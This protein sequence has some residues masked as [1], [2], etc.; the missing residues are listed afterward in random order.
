MSGT[1]IAAAGWAGGPPPELGPPDGA[2]DTV[3]APAVVLVRAWLAAGEAALTRRERRERRR[4]QLLTGDERSLA[5]T[6]AF[7]DRVLRPGNPAVA[8]AQLREVS[9]GP[10]PPFLSTVDRVLLRAGVRLGAVA[11]R[12]VMPLTRRRLRQLVG[13]LVV[14]RSDPA[15]AR[16]LRRLRE[17][18]FAVNVNLLGEYVLGEE[19]AG[20]RLA[21]IEA[22]LAR[23]DI[24]YVSVK[25]SAV[26]SQ[27]NLWGYEQTLQR[28]MA[29][30]R[31]LYRAAAGAAG[32]PKFLNLDMEEY[33]DLRLTVDA[34]TRLLDEPELHGADAGIVLQAYLP[35]SFDVLREIVQ[36]ATRRHA[37]AGGTVK[38]RIVKGAN[39]AMESVDAAMHGWHRAP[40]ASKAETDA[41]YIRMLD[42][43]LERHRLSAVRIGIASHNLFDVAWGR[44]LAEARGVAGQVEVEMLQGMA[45]GIDRAVLAATGR[46]RLYTP[47]VAASDFDSA[48]AYLFR[49]LQENSH[50]ENFLRSSFDLSRDRQAFGREQSRF[51]ASVARRWQVSSEP[52]RRTL[53]DGPP[54][55]FRNV[56]DTDATDP[57]ARAVVL[58]ALASWQP[59]ELPAAITATVGIDR[60]VEAAAAAGGWWGRQPPAARGDLLRAVAAELAAHRPALLAVMAHEA[61]KTLAEGDGEVSEAVD[62]AS[63]YAA[64]IPGLRGDGDADAG[65]TPLGVVLVTP[66]WNFP[67]AIPTGGVLAALG[68]GNTVVLK[69]PPQTPQCALAVAEAVWAACRAQGVPA[70]VL[71]F[72]RCPEEVVGEHLV[73]HSGV[74]GI[75]LTGARET[76]QRF[77]R[78]APHTPLFAETSG[79]NA[80][81]VM[82][83]A[84]LDLAAADLV[85]SAFGHAGQKCSAASLA[86]CVGDVYSSGRF[87]R[88]LVDAAASLVPGPAGDPATTVAPLIG[89]PSRS[90]QRALTSLDPGERWLLEPRLVDAERHLWS[91]GIKDGV[92]PGSWF[93]QT[94]CFGPVLGL[95]PAAD[96]EEALALQNGTPYGLTGGIHTLDPRAADRWLARVQVGNAYVNRAITGAVVQRQPFGGWKASV[97][98]PGAKAGGPN[99]VAQLGRWHDAGL[100]TRGDDPL[101]AI[102]SWLAGVGSLL[103]APARRWLVA[104]VRSD[105]WWEHRH[106]AIDHDPAGL[107]CEANV[108]RYRPLGRLVMWI[109][110]D[111]RQA[112]VLRAYTAASLAGCELELAIDPAAPPDSTLALPG[113]VTRRESVADLVARLLD[114]PPDRVRVLG[115]PAAELAV[116]NHVC[117]VDDAPTVA[118]GLVEGLRWRR[119]QSVS[120]TLHRFGNLI[121]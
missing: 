65:F 33:A 25:A 70:G 44:L 17:S 114:Q 115:T 13:G 62:L 1:R 41:N 81:V 37:A 92:G 39:L 80:L 116:L 75:V 110:A 64:Q 28:V 103:A 61:R 83:D 14:D 102:A 93:H 107:F 104:A 63:Y 31:R 46:V 45:P 26:A 96:L 66:P 119:E 76:A 59:P 97:V 34:F 53:P 88:Q 24:D 82:P 27:L 90:L 6:M 29:A 48:L 38:V 5:F 4:F 89:P 67:L 47:V 113:V 42:W 49:R 109:G 77:G 2:G 120:R 86:I 121:R 10:A 21:A 108:F 22:L 8:A 43:A 85:H 72:A 111:A 23:D 32:G 100:P 95:M 18:G 40:Y 60:L 15:L 91:P 78:L 51:E 52:R 99:Y 56:A 118:D 20:R 106:F 35:D 12:V 105:A 54:A 84:D 50:D 71:Q 36:W 19:E 57:A 3:T 58:S 7:C 98:G 73:A 87:R 74:R 68:A 94:E 117:F 55:G 79:K 69:A 30:L 9:R 11:P 112:A 16:H 101:P